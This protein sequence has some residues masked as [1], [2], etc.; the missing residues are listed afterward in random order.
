[1]KRGIPKQENPILDGRDP[2]PIIDIDEIVLDEHRRSPQYIYVQ[3]AVK[4]L[5]PPL[6][7]KLDIFN[8][9]TGEFWA[10]PQWLGWHSVQIGAALLMVVVPPVLT[11]GKLVPNAYPLLALTPPVKADLLCEV[12]RLVWLVGLA[13]LVHAMTEATISAVPLVTWRLCRARGTS[14]SDSAHRSIEQLLSLQHYISMAAA[15]IVLAVFARFLYPLEAAAPVL[16][17]AAGQA[18]ATATIVD[19]TAQVQAYLHRS[20][21]F[22]IANGCVCFGI[23]ACIL[24]TEK[25]IIKAIA[26][27]YHSHGL[28]MRIKINKFG[29][30]V[31]RLLKEYFVASNPSLAKRKDVSPGLLIFTVL[32]KEVVGQADFYQYMDENEAEEYFRIL[33][34][35]SLGSLNRDQFTAAVDC[36]YLEQSAIDRAF[37]EQNKIIGLLDGML[38]ALVW[39]LGTFVTSLVLE[40]PLHFIITFALVFAFAAVAFLDSRLKALFE[41]II[42]IIFTHPF[43]ADDWVIIDDFPYRVEELGLWTSTFE[44]TAG[45]MVYMPNHSLIRKA[46]INLRRSPIMN[47]FVVIAI[48]PSTTRQQISQL[49]AMLLDWLKQNQRD[50]T[51]TLFIRGMRVTDSQHM[52]LELNLT[53]RSN[54][55]DYIKKEFRTRK[56]TMHLRD[57]L[58][59][60]G[61]QLSPPLRS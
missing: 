10:R 7:I 40:A 37:L 54:F 50:F 58:Q 15:G 31:T 43:D 57:C 46:I 30:K 60:L 34:P 56:F 42:F 45:Q 9:T 24:L 59:Q 53:H 61:I 26:N 52:S 2:T 16:A 1:M 11:Y 25:V 36:L 8:W 27:R 33:D 29:R 6:T 47:E 49:E 19:L 32:G 48:M 39:V 20:P 18:A 22:F 3:E 41:S 21:R 51:P 17:A 55:N 35:D 28:A 12:L 23:V 4:K 5:P 38:M 13:F 44:T 14:A